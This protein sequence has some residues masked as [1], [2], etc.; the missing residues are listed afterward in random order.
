MNTDNRE[1][2]HASTT[3]VAE[4]EYGPRAAFDDIEVGKDLGTIEWCISEADI[5]KQC[6]IDFDYHPW[7]FLGSPYGKRIAPPQIQ[8]RPPRWLL[9]RNYNLR[10]LFYKWEFENVGPLVVDE[11]IKVTGRVLDK[12]IERDREYVKFESVGADSLGNVVFRT[13]RTHVLD[14]LKRTAPREGRGLDS[15]IKSEKL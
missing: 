7:Y 11:V 2:G 9:S 5:E 13:I 8:Y 12:W 15:G 14:A 4:D 6:R 1:I 3:R 10:G